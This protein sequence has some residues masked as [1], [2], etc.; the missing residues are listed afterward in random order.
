MEFIYKNCVCILTGLKIQSPSKSSLFDAIPLFRN[1][2]PLLN[3]VLEL[4]DFD[5]F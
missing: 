4:V 2:F 5:A 1:F 3:T